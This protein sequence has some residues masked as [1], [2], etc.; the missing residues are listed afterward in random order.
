MKVF[1]ALSGFILGLAP[2]ALALFIGLLVYNYQT[3]TFGLIV[4]CI[5]AL[6]GIIRGYKV[7]KMVRKVGPIFFIT[8]SRSAQH[9]AKE[10]D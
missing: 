4:F 10:N 6:L 3:N 5:L 9:I 7:F 8:V 2:V 1:R